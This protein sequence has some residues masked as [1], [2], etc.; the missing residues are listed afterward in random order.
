M[1]RL[2]KNVIEGCNR[3]WRYQ[4]GQYNYTLIVTPNDQPNEIVRV[5]RD[6]QGTALLDDM[7]YDYFNAETGEHIR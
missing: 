3:N 2:N 6:V 5:G 7:W 1:R 4:T